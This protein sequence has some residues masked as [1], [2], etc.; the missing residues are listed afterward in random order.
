MTK[1][2]FFFVVS[3]LAAAGA[4]PNPAY[5]ADLPPAGSAPAPAPAAAPSGAYSL[6]LLYTGELFDNTLGGLRQG[7]SYMNNIDAQLQVDTGKAF[8]WTGGTFVAEG[9]YANAVSTGNKFV[10]ALDQQSPIDT[11]AGVAMFRLYQLYYDQNFGATDVRFGIYDLET[12]FSSLKPEALFM[13]KDLTWNTALDQAGTMP[14][15][16]TIGPGNYPYTPLA[17]RIRENFSPSVSV[18]VAV[19]NGA[20]D[21]PNN[22][23]QNG[24]YFS[25]AYGAMFMGEA[26]YTPDKY[27]K[28]MAG[29]WGMTSKLPDFGQLNPGG[30]QRMIY[31]ELGAYVGGAARLYNAGNHRGLDAFFTFGAATPQTTNV[32][33]SFNAGLVYTGL[34]DARPGDKAGVS[35]NVNVA[36]NNWRQMQAMQGMTLGYAETSFEATYRA[37]IN[38]YLTIQPDIQY[39]T[40]PNYSTTLKSPLVLGLHFELGHVFEW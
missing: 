4:A 33:Q 22:L 39:I 23:A 15:N 5:S 9:F 17:L 11:A 27:T 26:D 35:M 16:G 14:M 29:A 18:Q 6:N 28:L 19:A 1:T 31:G 24:V 10:G 25:Q 30:S 7:V 12:E 20:A 13:S 40:Q 21:N 36:S 34:L 37:K 32:A 38:E 3:L 2:S 8:G